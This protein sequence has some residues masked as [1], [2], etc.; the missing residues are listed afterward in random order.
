[1]RHG[2][3]AEWRRAALHCVSCSTTSK[4]NIVVLLSLTSMSYFRAGDCFVAPLLAMTADR[5]IKIVTTLTM[6]NSLRGARSAPRSA[7][8]VAQSRTSLRFVQHYEQIQ[9]CR[10]TQPNI[11]VVLPSWGLLRRSAPRNDGSENLLVPKIVICQSIREG[12]REHG[13]KLGE[14]LS[15]KPLLGV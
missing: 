12:P 2:A 9:H 4:S 14:S 1:V 5:S 15:A 7:S 11:N 6:L 3:P 10:T 13:E 8:G